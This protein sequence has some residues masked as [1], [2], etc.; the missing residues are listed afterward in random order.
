MSFDPRLWRGGPLTDEIGTL[1][2]PSGTVGICDP[3]TLF[4][5]VTVGPVEERGLVRVLRDR[6]GENLAMALVVRATEPVRW[7]EAGAFGVDAGMAGF[8]DA[9]LLEV[10]D[11][12][13][14]PVSIYDDLISRHLDPAERKGHAGALVPFQDLAFS[15]C[16]SGWGDGEYPVWV[17]HDEDDRVAVIVAIFVFEEA[18]ES[19]DDER[20][21][22]D[23]PTERAARV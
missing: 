18:E 22:G 16:R 21:V 7:E 8:F 20:S 14:F 13:R 19:V 1:S 10:L 12:H 2:I 9:A 5:P 4:E 17:G 6:R 11:E 3:G 15:A 23:E